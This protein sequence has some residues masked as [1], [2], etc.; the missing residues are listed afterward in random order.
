[1][2]IGVNLLYLRPGLVGGSEVYVRTLVGQLAQHPGVDLRLF[3]RDEAAASFA[4]RG[5]EVATI[6]KGPYGSLRRVRDENLVLAVR[7]AWRPV[8][9][10]WSPGNFAA[11]FLPHPVPQVAT[12]HDLQHHWLPHYFSRATRVQRSAFFAAT[13]LRTRRVIA[14]SEFTRQD[15]LRRYRLPASKV[16][17]VNQGAQSASPPSAEAVRATL[18]RYEITRPYF[19]YPAADHPHKNHRKMIAAFERF[20]ERSR[21]NATLVFSGACREAWPEIVREGIGGANVRHLGFLEKR[22]DVLDLLRGAAAMVFPSE[23]EGFG[24]PLT[25]AQ[26]LGT[27]I[28]ASNRAAIP[29]VVG[30]GALLLDPLDTEAWASAMERVLADDALRMDLVDRGRRNMT[31][32]SWDRCASETLGVLVDAANLGKVAEVRS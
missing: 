29:E 15:V 7:L 31:R 3:C 5:I 19:Y 10:L 17:T 21:A 14:I 20:S 28:L 1:M 8:D 27:P 16:V 13:F 32:F 18:R 22:Q 12:V 24:L 6:S 30:D 11:P 2:R 25:E 23:F 9:V 4:A 26:A